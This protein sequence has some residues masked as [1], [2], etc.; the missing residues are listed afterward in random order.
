MILNQYNEKS[1]DSCNNLTTSCH[2]CVFTVVENDEQID[3]MVRR[4]DE[5][6]YFYYNNY[7]IY[8]RMCQFKRLKKWLD[9]I[10][11]VDPVK[12]INE[13]IKIRYNAV[14]LFNSETDCEKTIDSIKKQTLKPQKLIIVCY[15]RLG[16]LAQKIAINSGLPWV[17]HEILDDINDWRDN[18]IQ[19]FPAQF[20]AFIKEGHVINSDYFN[21]L[22]NMIHYKDYRFGAIMSDNLLIFPDGLYK[23]SFEPLRAILSNIE[24][25]GF[26]IFDEDLNT[27]KF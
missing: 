27:K 17:V 19:R 26:N 3:C 11:G 15:Q 18:I 6:D 22:N 1:A 25:V 14:I 13:E 10:D 9:N 8:K 24:K 20:Y 5:K 7:R 23:M 16:D 4:M 2:D 12:K 21:K